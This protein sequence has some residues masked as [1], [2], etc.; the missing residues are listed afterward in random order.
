MRRNVIDLQLK[1]EISCTFVRAA[2]TNQKNEALLPFLGLLL[3]D[4]NWI[5]LL[6]IVSSFIKDSSLPTSLATLSLA[7]SSLR[8]PGHEHLPHCTNT[9]YEKD[10]PQILSTARVRVKF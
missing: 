1:S 9:V 6:C 10:Y 8:I 4:V 7:L 5:F 3:G 2:S